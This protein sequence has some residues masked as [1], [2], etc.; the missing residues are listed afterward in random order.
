MSMPTPKIIE[1]EE[2]QEVC[3][4]VCNALIVDE[5]DGLVSQ[6]SCPHIRFV[7]ANGECFEYDPEGLETR[8]E[9][10]RDRADEAGDYF[11]EWETLLSL[12][13][14]DD[15]ILSQV[16]EGMACGA[17]T[18]TVWIGI[19]KT[20]KDSRSRI[21]PVGAASDAEYTCGDHR[22]FF[23]PTTNFIRWMTVQFG[24]ELIYDLGSGMGH[25]A[26]A[27]ATAGLHVIALDL[28]PRTAS[29]SEFE[30][31]RA[32]STQYPFQKDSVVMFCRPSHSGFV[33]KTLTKAIQS[34]VSHILYVGLTKNLQDDLG[35]LHDR[36]TKRR[37]GSVGHSGECVWELNV[38]RLRASV[39]RSIPRL[40]P[41]IVQ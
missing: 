3:C 23:Q 39:R 9:Q 22:I 33:E 6:P 27:L 12:C 16:S 28:V 38:K 41:Y 13:E 18:F 14:K 21:H 40:S 20:A 2:D 17:M 32:D 8:L 24:G 1:I 19:R 7:Y 26:K 35:S 11:D 29:V 15:L 37:I 25:V 4:P 10:E 30:V 5:E 31:L 36:F 34:R